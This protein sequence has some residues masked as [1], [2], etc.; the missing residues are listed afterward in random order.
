MIKSE[1]G[2][3]PAEEPAAEES[4]EEA[5]EEK[6]E[7]KVVEELK[8]LVEKQQK[9]NE[10]LKADLKALQEHEVFKSPTP[11]QPEMKAEKSTSILGLIK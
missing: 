3:K 7:V 9:E 4:K 8:A 5:V 10:T 2:E 11:T 6:A 1:E